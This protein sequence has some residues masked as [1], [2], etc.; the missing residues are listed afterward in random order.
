MHQYQATLQGQAIYTHGQAN[1]RTVVTA[2][3]YSISVQ[4]NTPNNLCHI[5]PTN[6]SIYTHQ[7]TEY[8]PKNQLPEELEQQE[9]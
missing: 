8:T 7:T 1:I 3:Y 9:Q 2:N 6:Y 4:K 5:H